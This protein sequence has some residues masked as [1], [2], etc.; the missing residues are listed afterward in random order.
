M[1]RAFR[2]RFIPNKVVLFVPSDKPP[3]IIQLAEFTKHQHP[4][5]GKATAYVC[6]NYSCKFPTTDPEKMLELLNTKKIRNRSSKR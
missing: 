1:L 4:I 5:N 2:E 3:E 6:Q